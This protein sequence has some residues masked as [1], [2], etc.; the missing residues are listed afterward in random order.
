MPRTRERAPHS[1][2][3]EQRSEP[4]NDSC[5]RCHS[6]GRPTRNP[7]EGKYHDWPVGY[8]VGLSLRIS[9]IE[10]LTVYGHQ[11]SGIRWIG[12]Q[13]L[14]KPEDGIVHGA[15][16]G[17]GS[18]ISGLYVY[19][20]PP[21]FN[22]IDRTLPASTEPNARCRRSTLAYRPVGDPRVACRRRSF[23]RWDV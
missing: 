18:R 8:R 4:A 7:I 23:S 12:L 16:A 2:Q 3:E 22:L 21:V 14:S 15:G 10:I 20:S 11:M 17:T 6:Q 1:S 13:S 19:D 5:I 9:S